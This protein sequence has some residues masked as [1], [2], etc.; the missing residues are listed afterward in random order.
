MLAPATLVGLAARVSARVGGWPCYAAGGFELS[1]I[2]EANSARTQHNRTRM[3]GLNFAIEA[4]RIAEDNHAEGVVVLDLRGIS[5]I[6]D[7]FVIGTGTSERQMQAIVDRVEEFGR[8]VGQKPFGYSGRESDS[9]VLA[10]YVDVV[11]HMFS[12]DKRRYYD[13]ELLWGDA[14]R[15]EWQRA[16]TA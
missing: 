16:A 14:P 2:A 8:K 4:A 3:D 15:V 10:D 6:A 7:F 9:W 12:P 11:V 1:R 5:S 13:L